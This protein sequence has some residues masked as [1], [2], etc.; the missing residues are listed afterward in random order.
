MTHDVNQ[1]KD[2]NWLQEL[3]KD[4]LKQKRKDKKKRL[5][6]KIFF[7]LVII[8]ALV[9]GTDNHKTKDK[10]HVA[11]IDIK[12]GIFD[13]SKG[14]A[15]NVIKA[16]HKAY[17]AKGMEALILRINSGGGSPVQADYVFQEI[18]RLKEKYKERKVYA[19]CSDICASA[20]Y[21]IAASADEIYASR[22][23]L[24]GSIGVL[25][26]GFGFV[27]TM[28]KLGVT[29]R[30]ITA[31]KNKGFLDPFSLEKPEDKIKMDAMLEIVHKVFE[32]SVMEGR[33]SRLIIN[34][35]TFSGLF[36]TGEQARSLGLID[37]FGNEWDLLREKTKTNKV[38]NYT[39]KGSV[40]ERLTK[41]MGSSA[42]V[43]VLEELG[44]T[45]PLQ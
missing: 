42:L 30:L 21:Y 36:W 9:V 37:G 3:A 16:L 31:G 14:S 6:Y 40:F 12:G 25:Y 13:G 5:V 22:V 8:I 32:K 44:Y 29:R 35:Q 17:R 20:A 24:V 1:I 19:V 10:P 34:D 38:I 41:E 28:D 2:E 33:G 39:E 27:G 11:V 45:T 43:G 4:Y 18:R 15:K 7:V 23:S 26:N